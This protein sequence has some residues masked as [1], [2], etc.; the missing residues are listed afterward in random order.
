MKF[1]LLILC[2]SFNLHTLQAQDVTALLKEAHRL[3]ALPDEKAAFEKYKQALVQDPNSITIL[4]QCSELCSRIGNRE[5]KITTR[6][7]YYNAAIAYAKK[8][9]TISASSDEANVAMAIAQGRIVMVKSGKEKIIAVKEIKRYA[10]KALAT[11]PS[12]FKA[13]HIIGKWNYEVSQLN[14]ME[15]AATRFLYG[16]LPDASLERA[17]KAYEKARKLHPSFMLNYL[18]LAKAYDK[19]DEQ[20]KAIPLLKYLTTLPLRTED[21]SRIKKEAYQLLKTWKA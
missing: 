12:N 13:W 18:E 5:M 7:A 8:A 11:N 14:M 19:N 10:D 9:L 20:N 17:I 6:G 3:E 2:I 15:R 1:F 16:G 21:D 4:S